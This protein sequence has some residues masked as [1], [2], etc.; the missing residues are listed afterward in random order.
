MATEDKRQMIKAKEAQEINVQQNPT[1]TGLYARYVVEPAN[2]EEASTATQEPIHKN[3]DIIEIDELV[4]THGLWRH[5]RKTRTALM[6]ENC[7]VTC[8]M[9]AMMSGRLRSTVVKSCLRVNWPADLSRRWFSV[10]ISSMSVST[11]SVR[12]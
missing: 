4:I 12:R 8:S 5:K 2:Q 3:T 9:Q 7:W 1:S 10:S 6:P 11:L